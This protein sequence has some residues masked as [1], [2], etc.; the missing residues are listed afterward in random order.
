MRLPCSDCGQIG[1]DTDDLD[2]DELPVHDCQRG[3]WMILAPAL[4]TEDQPVS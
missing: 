2:R 4:P 3:Q 1:P